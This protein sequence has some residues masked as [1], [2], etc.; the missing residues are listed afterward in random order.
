MSQSKLSPEILNRLTRVKMPRGY[1]VSQSDTQL[2]VDSDI[3][4]IY[5]CDTLIVGSGAAGLRASVELKRKNNHVIIATSGVGLGTSACSGS[6]KQ[7]LHTASTRGIG[8]NYLAMASALSA[9][10]AMDEDVAYSESVVSPQSLAGLEFMGLPIPKDKYGAA[11][12]YQTDHDEYGR[13]T[14]CGPRT[15]RLMVTTLLNEAIRLEIPII[16]RA[17]AV[18]IHSI[19]RNGIENA[20]GLFII[21]NDKSKN[22]YGISYIKFDKLIL[23]T[24]GPGELYRDSVYPGN[25]HGSLGLALESGITLSNLTESQFG[26]SSNREKF[27]WNLSGSYVQAMP[28]IYSEDEKGEQHNFL[29]EY[30][31][32]LASQCNAVFKK[33]YQWPFHAQKTLNYQSSLVDIAIFDQQKLDRKVF[34]DF[35]QNPKS[36]N[37]ETFTISNLDSEVKEYINNNQAIADTPIQ[38]LVKLNPLAI[39]LY[40]QNGT[41]LHNEP[42]QFSMNNQHMNGGIE[43][44]LWG[45]SSLEGCYAIGEVASTHGVTRPG[46]SAL[47]AGQVFAIRA[48]EHISNT[49]TPK[50]VLDEES[51]KNTYS[52]LR[53]E[54]N[55]ALIP[56]P[57]KQ[58]IDDIKS[59]IQ[60]NMSDY[61]GF[62][63]NY[64]G[65]SLAKSSFAQISKKPLFIENL[66][67][68]SN[69]YHWKQNTLA[70]QA[71][72]SALADYIEHSG[73]SR[74]SRLIC[75]NHGSAIPKNAKGYMENYCHISEETDPLKPL[76]QLVKTSN[77]AFEISWRKTRLLNDTST[78]YFEKNW[79]EYLNAEI[80]K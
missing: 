58:S 49:Q 59:D 67:Q 73:V 46:G 70:A 15:S 34:M 11:L 14:S 60:C 26:I 50:N 33:G 65:V 20:A 72:S 80:Y 22:P 32:T 3:M 24:G 41:D 5:H 71:I 57:K 17:S 63:C 19:K 75:N 16:N 7:T 79:P 18:K 47:N 23:A 53:E 29:Q 48:A 6:D 4:P 40:R 2:A 37:G 68:A 45:K 25:C 78:I 44:D 30:F 28:Y 27:P 8:D 62:I 31:P 1:T 66:D 36:S 39:E 13:A 35:N 21:T 61:V 74:G 38:R 12:R 9:G 69:Y 55:E 56:D 10:G 64:K 76:K 77:G 54:L 42:L 52:E 51:L 43:V